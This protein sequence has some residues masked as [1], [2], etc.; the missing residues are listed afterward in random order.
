MF[1]GERVR[2]DLRQVGSD[3]DE[4]GNISRCSDFGSARSLTWHSA[5][6][7]SRVPNSFG[8]T[9]GETSQVSR[10]L[11]RCSFVSDEAQIWG[12][13]VAGGGAPGCVGTPGRQGRERG[14]S[15]ASGWAVLVFFWKGAMF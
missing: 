10:S 7:C 3:L 2:S 5:A 4:V 1:G 14:A 8:E 6:V 15:A 13:A 11:R 9:S 12:S